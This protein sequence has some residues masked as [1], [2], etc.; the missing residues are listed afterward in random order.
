MPSASTLT[1]LCV[2]GVRRDPP[3]HI[4]IVKGVPSG[5]DVT[6]I[7]LC[8][9]MRVADRRRLIKQIGYLDPRLIPQVDEAIAITGLKRL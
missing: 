2:A 1:T 7:V 8:E 3:A 6:S 9:Q 4:L 5:L